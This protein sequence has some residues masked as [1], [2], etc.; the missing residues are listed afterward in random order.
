ML[1]SQALALAIFVFA[2]LSVPAQAA[3]LAGSW[4]GV[5]TKNGDPLPVTV[6]FRETEQ[7][8]AGSFDS[9]ALQ[10]SGIP[11]RD[12]HEAP[13]KV[14]FVLAGDATTSVFDGTLKDNVLAGDFVEGGTKGTFRLERLHGLP[15][16][17]Q[18]RDV[19]FRNGD[20]TLA[21][22]LLLPAGTAPHPAILFL[23]GS[24]PEGRWANRYL[25]ERFAKA[26]FAALI[27]DKRG[28]GQSTGDWHK[29]GFEELAADAVQ[30]IRF[31]QAQPEVAGKRIGIYGHSQGGTLAPLVARR[32]GDLAF[33]IG[34]AAGGIDPAEME[35]Y[36]VGN[37]IGLSALPPR[38]AAD[39]KVF[40]HA[41]VDVG[42]RGHPRAE[43][44]ALSAKFKDRPWFFDPPPPENFYWSFARGIASYDPADNWRQV[45]APVLLLFGKADERVPPGRSSRAIIAA[46]KAG[47]NEDVTLRMFVKADHTFTLPSSGHGWPK[48]V[49][50]YADVMI[51]WA[52]SRTE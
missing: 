8:L 52:R 11:F 31:L 10:V 14:H 27:Y 26:G 18:T 1:R 28:V 9:D 32:A 42:Y 45:K 39:A 24:G 34:A 29:A 12:V 40:V 25:A 23:Q 3:G 49:P 30:G 33:V 51:A 21:G 36:S 38:E 35:E 13:P 16:T 44:D 20:V 2:C 48:H 37:S 5:W 50:G 47:G 17:V 19:T 7:G 6:T 22:T 15:S 41:I 46:L 43:L 4:T